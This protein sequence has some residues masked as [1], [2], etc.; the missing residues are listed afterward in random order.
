[1]LAKDF[2]KQSGISVKIRN[3]EGPAMA[4]QLVAE[5]AATPADV[6]FTEN[7][8][9]LMLLEEKGLLS[10]VDAS[11]LATVPARFNSPHG[12]LGR[13]DRARKR[14]GLQ[15]DQDACI[16][17]AASLLDLAKPEWKGKVGIAPSDGD[18]LP[19]V[20][21]VLALKGE[22]QTVAWLKGLKAN[23][24]IF[25]DDEGV[26]AAVNRGGV[27]TGLINNYY[28]ARLHAETRRRENPQRDLSLRQRRRRRDW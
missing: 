9:E 11:T 18:F 1:M 17:T 2:E 24:Q 4:A 6:Y 3:G 22:A 21:A 10:K 7:S 19:L 23:S 26:V 13:R 8:P 5:G 28:W 15:H 14:A 16:A 20:S 12:R 25:D 27:A